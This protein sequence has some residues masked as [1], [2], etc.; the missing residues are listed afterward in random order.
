VPAC[1]S[2]HSP[3]G[4][5]IPPLYPR[6]AGQYAEYTVAQLRAS[7]TEQRANDLNSVMREIVTHMSEKEMRAVAEFISGLR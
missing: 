1:A 5:G 7:R 3:H 2:C 6:L 4:A